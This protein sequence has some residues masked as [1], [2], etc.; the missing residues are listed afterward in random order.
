MRNAVVASTCILIFVSVAK[1]NTGY[2]AG[3]G[4]TITLAKTEQIQLV[5]EEVII[6]PNCG[7]QHESDSVD[8]RC[9]F[10]LKNLSKQPV[11][12]L[13]GFPLDSQFVQQSKKPSDALDLV[14]DYHFIVRDGDKT[15]H[16]RFVPN[17]TEKRFHRLFVWDMEFDAGE[18][19]VLHVAYEIPMSKALFVTCKPELVEN[20]ECFHHKKPWH[21]SIEMA[22][23]ER[24]LY[25]TE[26]GTSWAGPIEKATFRIETA[27]LESCLEQ[28]PLFPP[29]FEPPEPQADAPDWQEPFTVP[30]RTGP[31]YRVIL[32]DGGKYDADKGMMTWEY[33][34]YKP[35]NVISCVYY[36]V[37]LPRKANDCDYWVRHVLGRRPTKADL[38]EMREIA[39]AYY[40]IA[41]QSDSAKE[42][43]ERQIWY[44]PKEGLQEAGLTTE[45][46]EV[47]ARLDAIIKERQ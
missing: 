2:F 15:Y 1:A 9:E 28:R 47:L 23:I 4:R 44:H 5:S 42:F 6:R 46:K 22:F 19:K 31:V 11:K 20:G 25:V 10:V 30:V 38:K 14:L 12:A 45:Q 26:T 32:P 18:T 39:A 40:G 13:V 43:V 27:G 24:F 29:D 7:W 21:A 16:V 37:A 41:P 35:G 33:T 3:S 17:D 34:N 36:V 8:Y